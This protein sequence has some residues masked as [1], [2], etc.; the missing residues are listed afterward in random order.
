[1]N[2]DSSAALFDVI[3]AIEMSA[4]A[5]Y[6]NRDWAAASEYSEE[7]FPLAVVLWNRDR[8]NA[9]YRSEIDFFLYVSRASHEQSK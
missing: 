2:A 3:V 4:R 8:T 9:L 7:G 1:M 5:A 6:S